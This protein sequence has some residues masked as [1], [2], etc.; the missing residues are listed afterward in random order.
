MSWKNM[1]DPKS[2]AKTFNLLRRR[3][4]RFKRYEKGR[5]RREKAKE[6]ATLSEYHGCPHCLKSFKSARKLDD[7]TASAH[8]HSCP[9]CFAVFP[10]KS[11]RDKHVQEHH[12]DLRVE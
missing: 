11:D 4:E 12:Q 9:K 8:S 10:K 3:E 7:H 5:D 1:V 6:T 2:R